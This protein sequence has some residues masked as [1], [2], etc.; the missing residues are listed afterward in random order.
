[1]RPVY[2]GAFRRFRSVQDGAGAPT[3]KGAFARDSLVYF[4]ALGLRGGAQ[5]VFAGG[6]LTTGAITLEASGPKLFG[7]ENK[8]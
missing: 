2:H 5:D 1:M 4:G 7:S 6:R 8:S 3:R